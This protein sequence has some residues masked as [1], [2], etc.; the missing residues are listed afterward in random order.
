MPIGLQPTKAEIDSVAGNIA[1]E[2]QALFD[3]VRNFKYYLDGKTTADLVALGYVESNSTEVSRLKSAIAD[4]DT[5]RLIYE[6]AATQ[7]ALKDF[8]TFA[9][10]L[11]G[12]GD[13]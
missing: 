3:R 2:A 1:R 7:P 9:R 12:M 11:Q 4:L 13:V 6:G 8:R 10:Q 5:L